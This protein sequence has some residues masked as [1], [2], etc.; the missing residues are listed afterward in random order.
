MIL[1]QIETVFAAF[2]AVEFYSHG[3]DGYGKTRAA[4]YATARYNVAETTAQN[5]GSA[6]SGRRTLRE[7]GKGGGPSWNRR[8]P[9]STL[10]EISRGCS[11]RC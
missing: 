7:H 4:K 3:S 2:G 5:V 9:H 11:T 6:L 1:Q 10:S 8:P